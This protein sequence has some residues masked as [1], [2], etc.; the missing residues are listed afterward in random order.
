V[1]PVDKQAPEDFLATA[2]I[3]IEDNLFW[4]ARA[5]VTLT[6][7]VLHLLS[8]RIAGNEV[9]GCTDTAISAL[10][11]G[12]PGSSMTISRNAFT[13]TGNGIRCG[14]D[15]IWIQDNKLSNTADAEGRTN[16]EVA[17]AVSGG[18]QRNGANQCQI[19]ANQIAGFASAGILIT[20]PTRDLIVK[21]NI[22]E[23]YGNGL[24]MTEEK[25]MEAQYRS[26]TIICAISAGMRPR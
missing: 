19:L 9:L 15:G 6:G 22:I 1:P 2:A 24:L 3:V 4:C 21:L 17:I 25:P 5:A 23:E 7:T 12:L 18:H 13:L 26:R 16:R 11:F 8:T 14:A 10:G 20:F